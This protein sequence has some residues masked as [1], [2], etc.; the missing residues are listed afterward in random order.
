MDNVNLKR[1]ISGQ[2]NSELESIRN[3][4]LLMGGLVEKQLT[5]AITAISSMDVSLAEEVLNSKAA[6]NYLEEYQIEVIEKEISEFK[7]DPHLYVGSITQQDANVS[8]LPSEFKTNNP[9]KAAL[10]EKVFSWKQSLKSYLDGT[11]SKLITDIRIFLATN[12]VALFIAAFVCI[13]SEKL[14]GR[15]M[16]ISSVITIATALSTYG[17]VNDNW[18][19]NILLNSFAGYGY[20]AGIVSLSAWLYFEY[21]DKF[22]KGERS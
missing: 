15:P 19:F 5:D 10:F 18:L 13:R 21:G 2:F 17:Y 4:V 1:H 11:F 20:S 12:V 22:G 6:K 14:G 8:A 7:R 3:H 9:L 16:V